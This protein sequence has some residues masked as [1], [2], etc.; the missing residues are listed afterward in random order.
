MESNEKLVGADADNNL[1]P[2]QQIP[3][4]NETSN[5]PTAQAL[6]ESER[7]LLLAGAKIDVG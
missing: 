1:Q 2:A 6:R 3:N 7:D 4:S 5:V